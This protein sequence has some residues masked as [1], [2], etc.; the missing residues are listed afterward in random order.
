MES[1]EAGIFVGTGVG[2]GVVSDW[3][4]NSPDAANAPKTITT[5]AIAPIATQVVLL[6]LLF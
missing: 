5:I 6:E 3:L 4:P 2:V 1:T